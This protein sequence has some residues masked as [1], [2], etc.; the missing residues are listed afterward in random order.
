L[1]GV[2]PHKRRSGYANFA[3]AEP[4]VKLV[5]IEVPEETWAGGVI[6]ALDHLGVEVESSEA[7]KLRGTYRAPWVV[8]DTFGD[9]CA[10]WIEDR[11]RLKASSWYQYEVP[12]FAPTPGRATWSS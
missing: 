10:R 8:T 7:D 1:F 4:P 2:E 3:I 6:G 11:C 12:S 9:C 5:L